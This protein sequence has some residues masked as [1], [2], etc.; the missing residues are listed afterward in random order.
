[1]AKRTDIAKPAINKIV[2]AHVEKATNGFVVTRG[3]SYDN[4][5]KTVICKDEKELSVALKKL[6]GA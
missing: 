2:E 3:Q 1:M 5:R 6:L 4:T